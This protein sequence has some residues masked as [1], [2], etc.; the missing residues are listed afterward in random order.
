MEC[1][2]QEENAFDITRFCLDGPGPWRDMDRSASG[3][4][5]LEMFPG[6]PEMAEFGFLIS[7]NGHSAQNLYNQANPNSGHG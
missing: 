1:P 3:E 6:F 2:V 4:Y 5:I 7:Q